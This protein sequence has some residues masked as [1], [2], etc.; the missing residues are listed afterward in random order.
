MLSKLIQQRTESLKPK[1]FS[2]IEL[3]IVILI[4]GILVTGV[5]QGSR[6]LQEFNISNAR[7]IT[8]SSD[9]AS[10]KGLTLWL[11]ATNED[12]LKSS[13]VASINDANFGNIN[14]D[15]RISAWK[16]ENP[17]SS[18]KITVLALSDDSR[19]TY[20]KRGINNIPSLSFDDENFMQSTDLVPLAAGDD[21][22]TI[23]LVV[24]FFSTDNRDS[25]VVFQGSDTVTSNNA[26]GIRKSN[27]RLYFYGSKNDA[28]IP[29]SGSYADKESYIIIARVNN[30]NSDNVLSYVNNIQGNLYSSSDNSTLEVSDD[31]FFI[32][33]RTFNDK[34]FQF[35]GLLSEV[36]YYDRALKKTEITSVNNYL[37]KKYNIKLE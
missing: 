2:L 16:D 26:A 7:T 27:G 10:I 12:L 23:A 25:Y 31:G 30:N 1:A 29:N 34:R 18:Q 9:V 35:N 15:D 33:S 3:S 5:T 13:T 19:P 24:Q 36:I 8:Q 20:V 32:G 11:D 6:L 22:Y 14:I 28:T 37:A 17:Q 4:I 21:E